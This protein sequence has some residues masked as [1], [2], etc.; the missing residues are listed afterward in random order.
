MKTVK[1]FHKQTLLISSLIIATILM[2]ACQTAGAATT[3]ENLP[4]A[5][6]ELTRSEILIL[7]DVNE[8]VAES[9]EDFQPMA[10]Y[11]AANLSDFGIKEARVVV[12]PDEAG[13]TE[14]LKNGETD[15]YFDSSFAAAT[16]FHDAGAVP[17]LRRWKDG[18]K[19]YNAVIVVR[20]DSGLES[21]DDLKGKTIAFEEDDSTSGFPHAGWLFAARRLRPWL[22]SQ[23]TLRRVTTRLAMSLPALKR[24]P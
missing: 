20:K 1:R 23:M 5:V 21:L 13:M 4:T 17:L 3:I 15:L 18:I 6:P 22:R 2:A 12:A 7:A 19:E 9:V 16:V 10:D 8:D 11:L 14:M 24:I